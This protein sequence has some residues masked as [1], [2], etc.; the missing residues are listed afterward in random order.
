MTPEEAEE[1]LDDPDGFLVRVGRSIKNPEERTYFWLGRT[2][3]GR[4]LT[5]VLIDKGKGRFLL[6]TARD[7]HPEKEV[8]RYNARRD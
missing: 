4:Y 8:R 1:A 3:S 7:Q 5:L 2:E 6:L